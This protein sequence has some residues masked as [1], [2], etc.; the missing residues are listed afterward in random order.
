MKWLGLKPSHRD[1]GSVQRSEDEW[2]RPDQLSLFLVVQHHHI[3]EVAD[4]RN[5]LGVATY[6]SLTE[7]GFAGGWTLPLRAGP[8]RHPLLDGNTI[9]EFITLNRHW[10]SRH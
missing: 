3:G 2:R 5:S 10:N 9:S 8:R 1:V 4:W 7:V 6:N